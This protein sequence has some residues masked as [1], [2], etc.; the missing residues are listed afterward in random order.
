MMDSRLQSARLALGV[1]GRRVT[2]KLTSRIR[3]ESLYVGYGFVTQHVAELEYIVGLFLFLR[4][5]R[6]ELQLAPS[7]ET[8]CV[9]LHDR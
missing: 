3:K 7:V 9:Q 8:S 2:G 6:P 4:R 5:P 1:L